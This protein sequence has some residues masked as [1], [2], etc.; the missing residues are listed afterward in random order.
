M[1]NWQIVLVPAAAAAQSCERPD[2]GFA[3]LNIGI[4]SLGSHRLS[5]S[6]TFLRLSRWKSCIDR[7]Q[8]LIGEGFGAGGVVRRSGRSLPAKPVGMAA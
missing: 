5:D 1:Q 6:E 8:R 4:S 7:T 3:H 2:G